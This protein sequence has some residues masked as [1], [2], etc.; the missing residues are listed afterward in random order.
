MLSTPETV[1]CAFYTRVSTLCFLQQRQYIVL[2]TPYRRAQASTKRFCWGESEMEW[3]RVLEE[4]CKVHR[5]IHMGASTCV[6]CV[7]IAL[8]LVRDEGTRIE[9]ISQETMVEC[10][11]GRPHLS[12]RTSLDRSRHAHPAS[13]GRREAELS[14]ATTTANSNQHNP[15]PKKAKASINRG[16][17]GSREHWGFEGLGC[18]RPL[19]PLSRAPSAPLAPCSLLSCD[20]RERE[21]RGPE[22]SCHD[23][24]FPLSLLSCSSSWPLSGLLC[25]HP[26]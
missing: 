4:R 9:L 7:R 11:R 26:A 1:H 6:T 12:P 22:V 21:E 17:G 23:L 15:P 24:L 20:R 18:D 2:S 13:G 10:S 25:P 14:N 3:T 16:S 8:V 19:A 5:P